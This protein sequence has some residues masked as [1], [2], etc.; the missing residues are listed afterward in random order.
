MGLIRVL[1]PE[2]VSQIAAGEVVERPA[3]VIKEL[4]ENSLDA[5]ARN[6]SVRLEEAGKTMIQVCD[7]GCGMDP[8]DAVACFQRHATSKIRTPDDL[9]RIRTLGFRGEALPSIAA[10]S[11]MELLTRAHGKDEGVK[12][13][14]EGGAVRDVQPAGC[15]VGTT[16]T[17][18][19]LFFNTPAR[20]KFLRSTGSEMNQI[21]ATLI[22]IPLAFPSVS[23]VA[24]QGDRELFRH[25]ATDDLKSVLI[26]ALGRD[27][28]AQMLWV[29]YYSQPYRVRGFLSPLSVT[30]PTR[31]HQWFFVNNR[32]VRSKALST[33][34]SHAYDGLI[35][36]DRHPLAIV[37]LDLPCD[38]V[39]VNVHPA[40]LEVRFSREQEVQS[41][42]VE[43]IRSVLV[44]ALT[45]VASPLQVVTP[46]P[47]PSPS[48]ELAQFR[49][50]LRA[51]FGRGSEQT[52]QEAVPPPPRRLATPK[53]A[54]LTAIA[55]WSASYIL[56]EGAGGE[57]FI[58]SQHRAH[59]KYLYDL[60]VRKMQ[61]KEVPRQELIVPL[62]LELG[63]LQSH[64]V[65]CHLSTLKRAGFVLDPF[66]GSSFLVR[67]IPTIL[68]RLDY[69]KLVTD[70]I[71]EIS[72]GGTATAED[73]FGEILAT[74]A[75]RAAIRAGEPLSRAEMQR[76]LD[77]LLTVDNPSL[78][79]HG[80]PV[81]IAITR[82]ELD[83]RFER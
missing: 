58:V 31:S 60:M 18:R 48:R 75:C 43:A 63:Q 30:R 64:F 16:V 9:I 67:S 70:L 81:M 39:D 78:C 42:L 57:L 27:I 77:D 21:L 28:A 73:L 56:A 19:N 38:L 33:A 45:P 7:D 17:V 71:D 24:F 41:V 29:D 65:R 55:Q 3:S 35:R 46:E 53:P 82:E 15:P 83:R 2:V 47:T 23:L 62:H 10:V 11:R 4:I 80:Q 52:S 20:L 76:L 66:G 37:Y 44:S 69:E 51:R 50:L 1:P 8:D 49:A 26:P 34:L 79:P 36:E 14:V 6:I 72:F 68:A 54:R 22:R 5:G 61:D 13:I 12:V 40:K 32:Y 59:E 25:S 74:V